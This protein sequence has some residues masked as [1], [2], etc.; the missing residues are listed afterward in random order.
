MAAI[1]VAICASCAQSGVWVVAVGFSCRFLVLRSAKTAVAMSES[2]D[3]ERWTSIR[4][5][6]LELRDQL[7][8]LDMD[9]LDRIPAR[10]DEV[11]EI[12]KAVVELQNPLVWLCE[13]LA[14][15]YWRIPSLDSE[16]SRSMDAHKGKHD[17]RPNDAI[18]TTLVEFLQKVQDKVGYLEDDAYRRMPPNR[19]E[20]PG[21]ILD[22]LRL[23][24]ELGWYAERLLRRLL[25]QGASE[26]GVDA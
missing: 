16:S 12:L 21:A 25:N 11:G 15:R 4:D 26:Q 22:V 7:E 13:S 3:T 5:A 14:E 2:T 18:Q 8:R 17:E 20:I 1:T 24:S 10:R 6:V 23:Q 9:R 19:D